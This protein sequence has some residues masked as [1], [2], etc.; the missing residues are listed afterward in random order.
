LAPTESE[1]VRKLAAALREID[2]AEAARRVL[3]AALFR[4]PRDARFRKLWTDF[5]Y[6]QLWHE[7]RGRR[8]TLVA[9]AEQEEPVLLP[10]ARPSADETGG[11]KRIRR[12]PAA[13]PAPPHLPR[14]ARRR[15]L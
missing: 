7:Q 2:N 8:E 3:L 4:N 1:P 12:D 13:P 5:Q 14:S 15:A 10:F 9:D 11:T 6:Q